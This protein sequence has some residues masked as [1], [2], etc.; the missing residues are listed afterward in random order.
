MTR[1]TARRVSIRG[2][3][4]DVIAA[5]SIPR[6]FKV[7][8][9]RDPGLKGL[10]ESLTAGWVDSRG[11]LVM[12]KSSTDSAKL[13]AV[14]IAPYVRDLHGRALAGLRRL[15][16]ARELINALIRG[17]ELHRLVELGQLMGVDYE[18]ARELLERALVI[19]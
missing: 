17:G 15:G 6:P 4:D 14:A 1:S 11:G 13:L 7:R 3:V 16:E 9:V 2:A 8:A 19:G 12:M 5:L 18:R 10:M